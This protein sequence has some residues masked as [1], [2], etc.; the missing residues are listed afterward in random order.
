[1]KS[2]KIIII[3]ILIALAGGAVWY[4]KFREEEKPLVVDT[5]HPEYGYISRSVTATGTIE[6]VDTVSVGTQV[7]GTIKNI[8]AD[9]NSKDR[10]SVV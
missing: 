9:F 10:K 6:P 8:Y 3:I 4:F 1:M 7:S 5:E 2:L